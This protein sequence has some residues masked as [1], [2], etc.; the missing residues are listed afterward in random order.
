MTIPKLIIAASKSGSGKTTLA[1]GL[2]R[3]LTRRGLRVAAVKCGPDYIDPAFHGAATR[4]QS[5]NIDSW[6]M[7]EKLVA[8]IAHQATYDADI[9]IA[10]GAMGLFDG[11]PNG[12]SGTGS[13]A[14]IAKLMD[15]P[16]LLIHDVSGQAQTSA[17]V[18]SGLASYDSQLNVLGVILNRIGSERHYGLVASAIEKLNIPLLG[19]FP[20]DEAYKIPERHLGLIQ[21]HEIND[22][23]QRLNAL[24]D[25]VESRID[26][27]RL[28]SLIHI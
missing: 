27:D 17:A 20:R 13:S 14:D 6:A 5:Y 9:L 18:I 1:L 19:A 23:D 21:A 10:E 16:V 25:L 2:M 12:L 15:W 24:S 11:A 4:R 3:A 22:L 28:L 8:S 26:I 7:S